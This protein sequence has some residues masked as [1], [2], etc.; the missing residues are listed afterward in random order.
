MKKLL[1]LALSILVI[2]LTVIIFVFSKKSNKITEDA[3][4]TTNSTMKISSSAFKDS[5]QIPAK[6]TC[7]GDNIN[8]PLSFSE[9]PQEAKSLALIVDDPDSPSGTWTHWIIWNISPDTKEIK[10]ASTPDGSI[11]GINSFSEIKYGG[12]CPGQ[13]KHH[14]LFK[15]YALDSIA[16]LQKGAQKSQLEEEIGKHK[17]AEAELTGVYE[18]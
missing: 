17:I 11:E 7:D 10:E 1:F 3:N 2:V 12:P 6:Y 13:G 15:L 16:N 5:D 8:P 4:S 9:V 18:R 14:Y